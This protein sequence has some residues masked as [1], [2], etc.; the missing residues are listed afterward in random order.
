MGSSDF[1]RFNPGPLSKYLSVE[2]RIGQGGKRRERK[3]EQVAAAGGG[4]GGF[5]DNDFVPLGKS[6]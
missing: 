6:G 3:A 4:E 1:V 5:A 2:E